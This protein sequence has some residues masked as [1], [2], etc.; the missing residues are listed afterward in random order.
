VREVVEGYKGKQGRIAGAVLK[1][2]WFWS[3]SVSGFEN[4]WMVEMQS[5]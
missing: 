2:S 1:R 3:K 4:V 5:T